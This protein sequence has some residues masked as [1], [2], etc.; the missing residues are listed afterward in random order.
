MQKI[1]NNKRKKQQQ[2]QTKENSVMV[3]KCSLAD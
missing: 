3:S 2:K 1:K